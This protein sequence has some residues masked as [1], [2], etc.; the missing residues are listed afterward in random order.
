[1]EFYAAE[2]NLLIGVNP[3]T[4]SNSTRLKAR[5]NLQSMRRV[6]VFLREM[7][8]GCRAQSTPNDRQI[9]GEKTQS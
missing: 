3:R 1:M 5:K 8:F 4:Q 6:L 9:G 7:H 2:W